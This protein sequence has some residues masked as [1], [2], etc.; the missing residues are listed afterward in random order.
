M[1]GVYSHRFHL[2]HGTT[3]PDYI[4]PV[5]KVAVIKMCSAST[6]AGTTQ[7]AVLYL[8]GVVTWIR[9][10]PVN[11]GVFDSGLMVV[12]NPGDTVKALTTD[13]QMSMHVSGY[14]LDLLPG[15]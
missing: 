8:N 9:S 14:L 1:P 7:Q 4:V 3:S 15:R 13:S 2:F 10:I 12:A 6:G 11:S 5:G